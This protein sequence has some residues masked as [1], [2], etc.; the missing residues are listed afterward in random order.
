MLEAFGEGE[1][2]KLSEKLIEGV[3]KACKN[4]SDSQHRSAL[5]RATALLIITPDLNRKLLQC[6]AS[7]QVDLFTVEAMRTAVDCWQWLVTA[8]PHLELRFLQEMV[9]AWN[10]TAQR[11][12][13]LFSTAKPVT[14]PLASY[15]GCHL[16]PQE[17]FVKPHGIWLQFICEIVETAKYNSYEKVEMLASLIHRS[18]TMNVGAQVPCQTRHVSAVGVRFQ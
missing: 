15:E 1:S 18:L 10:C 13:G 7:S 14:S 17:P 16:E 2:H 3:K 9:S 11:K 6:I 5:W 4:R 8:K 12:L